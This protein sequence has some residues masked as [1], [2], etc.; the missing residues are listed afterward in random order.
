MV[1]SPKNHYSLMEIKKS[2][3]EIQTQTIKKYEQIDNT[4][5]CTTI[6]ESS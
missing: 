1:K 4:R 3:R 5:Y 2:T 6:R